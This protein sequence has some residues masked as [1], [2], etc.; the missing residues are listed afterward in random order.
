VARPNARAP[1]EQF[2]EAEA[3]ERAA[4]LEAQNRVLE[5]RSKD[6]AGAVAALDAKRRS[7][8]CALTE[9]SGRAGFASAEQAHLR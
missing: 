9:A 2:T 8:A 4:L 7:A 5:T 3:A 6:T 1:C